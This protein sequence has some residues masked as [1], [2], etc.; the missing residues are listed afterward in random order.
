MTMKTAVRIRDVVNG[1]G[2]LTILR[3]T[4]IPTDARDVGMLDI[5]TM[6]VSTPIPPG[7]T[8][9]AATIGKATVEERIRRSSS[10]LASLSGTSL[11]I[12]P[13]TPWIRATRITSGRRGLIA[14]L[15]ETKP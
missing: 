6:N 10:T 5:I 15:V 12:R 8:R 1:I 9:K 7:S 2:H 14:W 4:R 13:W 11:Q 3:G